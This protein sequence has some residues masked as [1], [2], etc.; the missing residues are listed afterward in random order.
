MD[1]DK[2]KSYL[3]PND[4]TWRGKRGYVVAAENMRRELKRK[5]PKTKFSV[6]SESFS[7][8]N[9]VRISWT[10]GPTDKQV[11]EITNKY[12]QG[13]FDGMTDCYQYVASDWTAAF[14]SAKYVTTSRHTSRALEAKVIETLKAEYTNPVNPAPTVE[15]YVRGEG[16]CITP[17][18]NTNGDYHW[19][20]QS[21]INRALSET[22]GK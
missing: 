4:G 21:L 7:M 14:G 17:I 15:E 8:G 6:T 12:Q 18:G 1:I 3:V 11:S 10:D 22:E 5:F 2:A 13:W 19:S 16:N 20:W 9:A